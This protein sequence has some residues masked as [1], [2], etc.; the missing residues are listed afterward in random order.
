MLSIYMKMHKIIKDRINDGNTDS[1]HKP[2][3]LKSVIRTIHTA[4]DDGV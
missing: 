2:W 1:E 4:A 3:S